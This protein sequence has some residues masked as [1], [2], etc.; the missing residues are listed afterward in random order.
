VRPHA[1]LTPSAPTE[2]GRRWY[3]KSISL[4]CTPSGEAAVNFEHSPFDGS[5]VRRPLSQPYVI[6]VFPYD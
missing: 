6:S 2:L 1:L 5:T 3:D 4:I